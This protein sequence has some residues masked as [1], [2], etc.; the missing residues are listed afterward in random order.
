MSDE[1]LWRTV[2]SAG[3][4]Q[5]HREWLRGIAID[6]ARHWYPVPIIVNVGIYYGASM[7]CIR[8]GA[9]GAFLVGIDIKDWGVARRAVLKALY[10]WEDSTVRHVDFDAPIHLLFLDGV[11]VYED[12]RKDVFGWCPKVAVGG[13]A[14]FN[15]YYLPPPRWG[16]GQAAAEWLAATATKWED[17]EAPGPI[18]A[19]RRIK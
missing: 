8:A 10:L 19:I 3:L 9:L 18:R 7:H 4:E 12:V 15:C 11:Q 2:K 1:P 6:C 14:I 17:I 13:V 16:I 5:C